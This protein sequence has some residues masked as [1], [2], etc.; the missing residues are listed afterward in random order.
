VEE[1][2]HDHGVSEHQCST[3]GFVTPLGI[4]PTQVCIRENDVVAAV[5]HSD[6]FEVELAHAPLHVLRREDIERNKL[7]GLE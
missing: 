6:A 7:A 5:I 1:W 2:S 3:Q 4:P